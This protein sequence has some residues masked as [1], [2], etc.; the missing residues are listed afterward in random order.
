MALSRVKCGKCGL[1][2][3]LA[4]ERSASDVRC[5]TCGERL[6]PA[7]QPP[8]SAPPGQGGGQP[9]LPETI[10]APTAVPPNRGPSGQTA[11]RSI[12]RYQQSPTV[13]PPPLPPSSAV[14]SAFPRWLV[15]A[16]F[17]L[18]AMTA[19]GFLVSATIQSS[20][21]GG[22]Q[23][24][25][26]TADEASIDNSQLQS[27]KRRLGEP[28]PQPR[29]S[30]ATPSDSQIS[31]DSQR[32]SQQS[33]ATP[34]AA[35]TPPSPATTPAANGDAVAESL[36]SVAVIQV[37]DGHGSGFMAAP[38]F[39]VTNYHVIRM[40]RISDI[41][42]GFPD[43]RDVGTRHFTADLVAENPVHDLAVLRVSCNVPPLRLQEDYRH[44]NGQKIVAIGSPGTGGSGASD[45]LPNLTTPGRLGPPYKLANGAEWWAL[46]MAINPGNSG[47]PIIDESLGHVVGV[48]VAGFKNTQ[49]QSLAVPHPAILEIVRKA[50]SSTEEDKRRELFLH[51]AR[52][53]LAH[54]SRLS[55]VT[56]VLFEASGKKADE[57]ESSSEQEWL[58]AFN[59][60]KSKASRMLS[61][62]VVAFETVVHA[63][64]IAVESDKECDTSVRLA[65]A[66]LREATAEQLADLRKPVGP[67]EIRTAV[68]RFR[69]SLERAASLAQSTAE[70]LKVESD[71]E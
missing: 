49:S 44:V 62:E 19:V 65:V 9:K 28:K 31:K 32:R 16:G 20:A 57:T 11:L 35:P 29:S 23:T 38:H 1:P 47:G 12:D 6:L 34:P 68:Q 7:S 8:R 2:F 48:A 58:E 25:H 52:F 10:S 70:L 69:E 21:P 26:P 53:C 54:M 51:R 67:R 13:L 22:R 14:E 36:P 18:G 63:E 17:G 55:R 50:Q 60:F 5:P 71:D 61:D 59:H 56:A 3:M 37:A 64:V 45:I 15:I 46:S 30:T 27:S 4:A 39:V 40:S 24:L 33:T 41:R 66:K 43:N 42:V